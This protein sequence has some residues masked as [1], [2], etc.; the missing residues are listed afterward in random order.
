MAARTLALATALLLALVVGVQRA[1]A[2][3]VLGSVEPS[4][5]PDAF[6]CAV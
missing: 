1:E 5:P 6:A 2:A 3:T 4:E